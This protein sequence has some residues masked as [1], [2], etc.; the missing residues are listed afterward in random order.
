MR[1]EKWPMDA[2]RSREVTGDHDKSSFGG[3]LGTKSCSNGF[4]GKLKVRNWR[5]VTETTY[6]QA[7][8]CKRGQ[9]HEKWGANWTGPWDQRCYFRIFYDKNNPSYTAGGNVKQCSCFGRTIWQFL[10][11]LD[12]VSI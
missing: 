6:F 4:K 7:F 9:R 1:P 12:R 2:L 3:A 8:C 5:Q 11:R 10:K